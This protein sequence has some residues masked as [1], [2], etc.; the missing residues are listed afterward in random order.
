MTKCTDGNNLSRIGND[1]NKVKHTFAKDFEILTN[2]FYENFMVLNSKKCHFTCIG[3]DRENETLKTFKDV[4]YKNS[5]EEFIL[6]LTIDNELNFDNCIRK[7]C[8]NLV[9]N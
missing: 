4:C 5:N 7:M 8:K 1:I 3:R 6:G 9:K 2:W